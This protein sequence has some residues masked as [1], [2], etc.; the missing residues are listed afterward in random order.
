MSSKRNNALAR[1]FVLILFWSIGIFSFGQAKKGYS[2][3]GSLIDS[4]STQP[5]EY[6]SVAIYKSIDNSLVTGALTNVK[7]VF[8]I[9]NLTAGK[10]QI[11]SSFVGYRTKITNIEINDASIELSQPILINSTSLFLNEVQVVGKQNEKQINIEKTKINV[12]QN[13]SSVSGNITDVFKS[14]ASINFDACSSS[15]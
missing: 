6:A 10:Y 12:A 14:Q 5:I 7:G 11:K 1:I 4:L 13:I 9:N 2:V 15:L 3:S 8:T